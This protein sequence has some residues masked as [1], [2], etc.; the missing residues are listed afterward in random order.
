MDNFDPVSFAMGKAAGGKAAPSGGGGV[1]VIHASLTWNDSTSSFDVTV[2]A[3]FSDILAAITAGEIV[4]MHVGRYGNDPHTD[5][6]VYP[7]LDAYTSDESSI[8]ID[9]GFPLE[10]E[11]NTNN[12]NFKKALV[13][14]YDGTWIYAETTNSLN[15]P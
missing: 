7:L 3:Q 6:E 11:I 14:Y 10:A 9:F 12:V 5:F 8:S 4:E 1:C 13:S 15:A 2:E